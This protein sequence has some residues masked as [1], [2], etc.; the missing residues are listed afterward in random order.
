MK[1]NLPMSQSEHAPLFFQFFVFRRSLFIWNAFFFFFF[2][3]CSPCWGRL[4]DLFVSVPGEA[5]R[6]VGRCSGVS[7]RLFF[8]YPLLVVPLLPY[9]FWTLFVCATLLRSP[10]R[11]F[12][13]VTSVALIAVG[14]CVSALVPSSI[15]WLLRT[16]LVPQ[17]SF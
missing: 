12:G 2:F 13:A 10:S 8:F 16:P 17:R 6:P 7:V 3:F 11:K 4:F 5:A 14:S 1:Y 15:S 9:F